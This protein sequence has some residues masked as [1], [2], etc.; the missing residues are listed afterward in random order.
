ML[1][2][3]AA[4]QTNPMTGGGIASG[5]KGGQIAGRVASKAIKIQKYDKKTLSEYPKTMF[6]EF[7][8]NYKKLYRHIWWLIVYM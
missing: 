3:D 1:V 2:G 8:R 5:M 7:G 6:K 4:H